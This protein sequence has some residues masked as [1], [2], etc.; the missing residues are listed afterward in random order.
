MMLNIHH[1]RA[2]QVVDMA[3]AISAAMNPDGIP[4]DILNRA[5]ESKADSL[6]MQAAAW[7]QAGRDSLKS[8]F[9]G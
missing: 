8:Q 1:I 4:A 7:K 9:G 5:A 3:S 6:R 2:R